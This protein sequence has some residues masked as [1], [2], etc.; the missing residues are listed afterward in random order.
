MEVFI[1]LL[2]VLCLPF[3]YV[4]N[5]NDKIYKNIISTFSC[6]VHFSLHPFPLFLA[7]ALDGYEQEFLC[8]DFCTL[9]ENSCGIHEAEVRR[10][11]GPAGIHV[12]VKRKY[13]P[14]PKIELFPS[15]PPRVTFGS[16]SKPV[17]ADRFG[18]SKIVRK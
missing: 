16:E 3:Y 2:M 4:Q 11:P 13:L 18:F 10:V 5:V 1:I 17:G 6:N 8:F 14:F 9:R 15:R 7:S 12:L